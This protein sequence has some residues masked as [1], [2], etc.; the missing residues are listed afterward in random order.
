MTISEWRTRRSADV[1]PI[2]A[3][4]SR[5]KRGRR[6][7]LIGPESLDPL[8]GL[9]NRQHFT[10]RLT[11]VLTTAA[12]ET[13]AGTTETGTTETETT[14]TGT[15]I[16]AAD[17][18][19]EAHRPGHIVLLCDLDNFK[20]VNEGLGH[21]VG[22]QVLAVLG[23][24]I[25]ATVRTGDTVARMG[26]DEFAILMEDTDLSEACT[27]AER[28]Q[29]K[30][31]AP[32]VIDGRSLN[33]RTSIG[34]ASAAPGELT[35]AEALR[36]A[37]LAMYEAK[38]HGKSGIALYEPRLHADAVER[39]QLS[40]D[41]EGAMDRAEMLLHYQPTVDLNTGR[42]VG[43][44]ALLRWQHPSKG[45]IAPDRFIPLAEQSGLIV[46]LGRWVLLTACRA[47]IEL[48]RAGHRPIISVNVAAAQLA[49]PDFVDQ[50]LQV[51]EETGLPETRLCLEITE[52]TVLKDIDM[53]TERLLSLR[54]HGIRIAIDDFGTG[55]S[56]LAYLSRLP[57]DV[58]K[59]DKSFVDR[60]M[61]DQN[62]ASLTMAIIAMGRTMNMT[63]VAEGV[64]H[65]GQASWLAEADCAYGQGYLW[66]RPVAL[67]EAQKLLAPVEEPTQRS[68][69]LAG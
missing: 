2:R 23:G 38:G 52:S 34:L 7:V 4:G 31:A 69:L 11:D 30:F 60:V 12:A 18:P 24:R 44:E 40:E 27:V 37:D 49:E 14:E 13:A 29:A 32:V 48:E 63:T 16:T 53:I 19:L 65:V 64:E 3:R 22:D 36:N 47:A 56:S 10:E 17:G 21:T 20:T 59:V 33:V 28:I 43:F 6:P 55:Y 9:A 67:G 5:R 58:L 1:D 57:L 25:L 39:L 66:S 8:T 35:S 42:I 50:V 68:D 26:G 45:M 51:L 61:H 15:G 54:A 62:G 41:L 46:R